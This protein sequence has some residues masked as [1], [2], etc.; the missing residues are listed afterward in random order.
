MHALTIGSQAVAVKI[1]SN[2][3]IVVIH[4]QSFHVWNGTQRAYLKIILMIFEK[5]QIVFINYR[6]ISVKSFDELL[7]NI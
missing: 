5:I 4:C 3:P 1:L 7:E 6:R 2:K